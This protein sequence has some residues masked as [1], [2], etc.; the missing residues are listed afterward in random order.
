MLQKTLTALFVCTILFVSVSL[1]QDA[2]WKVGDKIEIRNLSRE[3]VPGSVIGTVD[4]DGKLLYRVKLDDENAP[5]VYFNHAYPADMRSRGGQA[6]DPPNGTAGAAGAQVNLG[7]GGFAVGDMV[8]TFYDPNRGHNRGTIIEAGDR[9]YRVHYTGCG[10][11]FDEWV[12]ASLVQT[13]ATISRGATQITYLFGRWRTTTVAVGRNYA[14]WGSSPGIQINADG[15]YTWYQFAGRPPVKGSWTTDA[16]V[17]KLNEGT[18]KFD[19]IIVKDADG[20]PW[21]AFKWVVAN[22]SEDGIEIDRMCSGMSEVGS[23]VR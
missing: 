18:P 10:N 20:I 4:S 14:V 11:Q 8:D 15:T 7:A 13:P 21:K 2:Q 1:A 23:R 22:D 3:W 9:K 6:A 17:P 5:N 19:G 12:D 16:K